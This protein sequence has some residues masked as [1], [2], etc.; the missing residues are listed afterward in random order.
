VSVV[1][2]APGEPHI[3]HAKADDTSGRGLWLVAAIARDW[4]VTLHGQ[5]K[6]VWAELALGLDVRD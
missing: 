3:V 1:D 5:R 2:D 4:G 6:Q